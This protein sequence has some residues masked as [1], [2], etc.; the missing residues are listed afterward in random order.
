LLISESKWVYFLGVNDSL[1]DPVVLEDVR[2]KLN[3]VAHDCSLVYGN[4]RMIGAGPGSE[5]GE[6]YAGRFDYARLKRQNICHQAIFYRRDA[7]LNV[8]GF[9]LKYRVNSDWAANLRI[10]KSANPQYFGRTIANFSRGGLSSKVVDKAFFDDLE[11]IWT[12][13]AP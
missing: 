8:G 10:W 5:D 6:I 2:A 12:G 3:G 9:D 4:V 13:N 7:L 1:A 11:E